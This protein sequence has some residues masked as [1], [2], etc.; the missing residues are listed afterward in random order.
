MKPVAALLLVATVSSAVA[1]PSE[2]APPSPPMPIDTNLPAR[3]VFEG[4]PN[5][6]V[7]VATPPVIPSTLR[8][9][10]SF[11]VAI[12]GM[13]EGGES[14]GQITLA[15]GSLGA[16]LG[17]SDA[18]N[19]RIGASIDAFS[20]YDQSAAP[21]FEAQ[22][23]HP[24]GAGW[25][26]GARVSLGFSVNQGRVMWTAG[27]RAR[28]SLLSFGFDAVGFGPS[29]SSG[30]AAG[31]MGGVGLEGTAGKHGLVLGAVAGL[32]VGGILLAAMA[33]TH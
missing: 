2:P 11:A 25:R 4:A 15:H 31:L 19:V 10:A 30:H 29:G 28:H 9:Y 6:A 23:D 33:G 13:S 5:P 24:V 3:V 14:G 8:M 1:Q 21:G 26:V 18:L 22:L 12:G 32:I 20:A 17:R 16:E 7:T 27:L